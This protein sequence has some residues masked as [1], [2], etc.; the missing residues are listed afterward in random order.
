MLG[1][2][3]CQSM[4][5]LLIMNTCFRHNEFGTFFMVISQMIVNISHRLA[6]TT[7][8]PSKSGLV[9]QKF[10]HNPSLRSYSQQLFWIIYQVA[11]KHDFTAI[12]LIMGEFH[13][14]IA[15]TKFAC[16]QTSIAVAIH[17]PEMFKSRRLEFHF[18]WRLSFDTEM[19]SRH[20][21]IKNFHDNI[22][23]NNCF[24]DLLIFKVLI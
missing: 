9:L 21:H 10:M 20:T 4:T 13:L 19:H 3:E 18:L 8:L 7:V 12:C 15:T 5:S 11:L 2:T 24:P 23:F 17:T 22:L 14:W 6:E 16:L 1:S